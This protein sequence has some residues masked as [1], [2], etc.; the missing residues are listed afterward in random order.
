MQSR[1]RFDLFHP[2]LKLF[3]QSLFALLQE[4]LQK[5]QPNEALVCYIKAFAHSVHCVVSL[6]EGAVPALV[7]AIEFLE[8]D[9]KGIFARLGKPLV[10]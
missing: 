3:S 6:Q 1:P 8:N 7:G 2:S 9:H 10:L 4:Y 5:S